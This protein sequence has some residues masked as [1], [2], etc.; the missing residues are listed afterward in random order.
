MS[1]LQD[2]LPERGQF[3]LKRGEEGKM[4]DLD[5][6]LQSMPGANLQEV[7]ETWL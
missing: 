1:A 6:G 7:L 2:V 3:S 4:L 5:H